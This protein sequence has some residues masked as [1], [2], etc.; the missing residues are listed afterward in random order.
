MATVRKKNEF[1]NIG[2]VLTI[3]TKINTKLLNY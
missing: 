1:M 2:I 3:N